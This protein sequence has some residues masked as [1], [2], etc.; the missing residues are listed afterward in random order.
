MRSSS[1]A[2]SARATSSRPGSR[3]APA[4]AACAQRG[5]Y[6]ALLLGGQLAR[7][8]S[9]RRS[10]FGLGD[11]ARAR[12]PKKG[13]ADNKRG[14]RAAVTQQRARSQAAT[15]AHP[16]MVEPPTPVGT[17]QNSTDMLVLSK[18]SQVISCLISSGCQAL[19]RLP[20]GAAAGP[21]SGRACTLAT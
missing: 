6:P 3:P 1:S 18:Q 5:R 19:A 4:N 21:E 16:A 7:R 14:L 9:A 12:S 11:G 15:V 10:L 13:A 20:P 17:R 8:P 2:A